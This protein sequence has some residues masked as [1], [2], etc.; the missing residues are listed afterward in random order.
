MHVIN[1]FLYL[2]IQ[3]SNYLFLFSSFITI[4]HAHAFIDVVAFV[5]AQFLK[6]MLF[7]AII[8]MMINYLDLVNHHLSH[9]LISSLLLY[10]RYL[11]L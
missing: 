3:N 9:L 2:L 8:F 5:V 4:D 7:M 11:P 6:D 10:H 1:R